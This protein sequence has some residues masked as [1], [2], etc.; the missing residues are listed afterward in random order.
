MRI[1]SWNVNGL[2]ACAKKGFDAFLQASDIDVLALQ[3]VRAFPHQ[4]ES[5]TREPAGYGAAFS[6]AERPG[7]S[8]VAIYSRN[9]PTRVQTSLGIERFDVEGR[10]IEAHFGRL[11]VAS[12]YFPK[13]NGRDRDNSRVPYKLDFY[14]AVYAR[15]ERL[16]Q[17]GPVYVCGDYNTAHQAIDLARPKGNA[18]SSGF[19]PEERAVM[20]RWLEAGWV[21][22]FRRQHPEEEGHYSWWR[23]FGGAREN[24]VGWRIDYVLASPSAARRVRDA[25]IWAQITGSDHCPVGVDV[26]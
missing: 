11:V 5:I 12:V 14:A 1:V 21:D 22:T 13:G 18:K 19:L 25:F 26:E 3:E 24:N 10:Y 17:R 9:A 8:G 20:T 23:Q 15:I 2:R 4:L 7:Y 6:P 16:R